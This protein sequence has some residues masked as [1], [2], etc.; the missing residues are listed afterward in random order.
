MLQASAVIPQVLIIDH[1]D[2]IE[3]SDVQLLELTPTEEIEPEHLVL[4]LLDVLRL[5]S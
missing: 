3:V 4:A 5:L 2:D 1:T